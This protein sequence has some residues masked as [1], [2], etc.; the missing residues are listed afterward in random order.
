MYI[1]RIVS[2]FSWFSIC[3]IRTN[4][5]GMG[6]ARLLL[7]LENQTY[8]NQTQTESFRIIYLS[9]PADIFLTLLRK[10]SEQFS[11]KEKQA[12]HPKVFPFLT[13]Q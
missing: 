2:I 1:L 10:A 11:R 13:A 5:I 7:Q 3:R 6:R 9:V 4:Y 12:V 8:A